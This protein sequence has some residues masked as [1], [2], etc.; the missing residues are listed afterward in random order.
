M[1]EWLYEEVHSRQGQTAVPMPYTQTHSTESHKSRGSTG[2]KLKVHPSG[3]V[4]VEP[5]KRQQ[6]HSCSDDMVF[7]MMDSPTEASSAHV[8]EESPTLSPE[9][10]IQSSSQG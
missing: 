6:H 1:L 7:V 9:K 10:V 3:D 4:S 8:A 2:S 5:P